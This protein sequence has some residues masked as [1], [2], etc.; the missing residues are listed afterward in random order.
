[1]KYTTEELLREIE[2]AKDNAESVMYNGNWYYPKTPPE[3]NL[4]LDEIAEIIK[5]DAD[6]E[7]PHPLSLE[8]LRE[9]DGKPVWT[10]YFDGSGG[11]WG[12]VDIN[13]FG[14][15]AN[16]DCD[17]AYWFNDICKNIAYD[18]EPKEIKG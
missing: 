4:C 11:R 9:R 13:D 1:M 12:I 5:R 18:S 3:H 16:V 14:V 15:C 6:R 17:T 8:E 2:R 10:T 7:N